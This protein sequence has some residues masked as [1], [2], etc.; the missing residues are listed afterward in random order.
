MRYRSL[1]DFFSDML[2]CFGAIVEKN[3]NGGLEV[4]CGND[5]A[6]ALDIPEYSK[7]VF[8]TEYNSDDSIYASF[9]S[10]TFLNIP[11][12]LADRGKFAAGRYEGN[13]PSKNKL[14]KILPDNFDLRNA[15]YKL[16]EKN[17]NNQMVSY[18]V[19]FFRYTA[20][21]D[22]KHEGVLPVMVNENNLSSVIYAPDISSLLTISE[23]H[24]IERY[25]IKEV[26]RAAYYTCKSNAINLLKDFAKS[27]ERRMN[28]DIKRVYEYY[29]ALEKQVDDTISKKSALSQDYAFATTYPDN[30]V[31]NTETP[32]E[33]TKLYS[34]KDTIKLEKKLKIQDLI[35]KYALQIKL[36]P[37]TMIRIETYTQTVKISLKRRLN[38]RHFTLAYNPVTKQMDDLP[39]ECCFN[40]GDGYYVCDDKLHIIC[41]NCYS[42]CHDCT[43]QYCK[44]CYEKCP[45]CKK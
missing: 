41:G 20:M 35:A 45:K 31:V 11:R 8:K 21:S 43:R 4:V 44:L 15:T 26:Y 13:I 22:E 6:V 7:L 28:R 12:L 36:K 14:L 1:K 19:I 42:L 5:V 18:M 2:T 23:Y 25:G 24:P 39:C 29:D 9:D 3:Q 10:D 32:E 27:L 34:K 37:V 16:N 40:P 38:S 33:L 30:T 17:I